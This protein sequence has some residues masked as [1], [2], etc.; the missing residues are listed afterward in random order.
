MAL[1]Q[2]ERLGFC[3]IKAAAEKKAVVAILKAAAAGTAGASESAGGGGGTAL[4][5]P[6]SWLPILPAGGGGGTVAAAAA[7][8]T[9]GDGLPRGVHLIYKSKMVDGKSVRHHSNGIAKKGYSAQCG[10]TKCKK[11]N[12]MGEGKEWR[13]NF[14]TIEAAAEAYEK[15]CRDPFDL[16]NK[17]IMHWS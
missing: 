11:R 7:A 16:D 10:K 6:I 4:P 8:R 1:E 12:P 13:L 17:D 2:Y 5:W 3:P 9:V 14:D 15:H